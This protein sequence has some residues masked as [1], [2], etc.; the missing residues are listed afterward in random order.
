[1]MLLDQK[2]RNFVWLGTSLPGEVNKNKN[3]KSTVD[4][5]GKVVW[6]KNR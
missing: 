4:V 5:E 6:V 2:Q 3:A 1:M